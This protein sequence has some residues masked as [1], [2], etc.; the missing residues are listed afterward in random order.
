MKR[1]GRIRT[2]RIMRHDAFRRKL[3][4]TPRSNRKEHSWFHQGSKHN[5]RIQNG[6]RIY[7]ISAYNKPHGETRSNKNHTNII[8]IIRE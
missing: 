8:F 6:A 7:Y 5:T 4:I 2:P 1:S 3:K